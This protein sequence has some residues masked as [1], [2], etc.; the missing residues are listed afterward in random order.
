MIN[1]LF[2]VITIEYYAMDISLRTRKQN[3]ALK[4]LLHQLVH[5]KSMLVIKYECYTNIRS[6][7]VLLVCAC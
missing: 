1:S 3:I 2:A 7:Y 6:F 5:L 4:S